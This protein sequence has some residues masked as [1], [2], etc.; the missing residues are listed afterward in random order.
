[1]QEIFFVMK[2]LFVLMFLP[3]F[4]VACTQVDKEDDLVVEAIECFYDSLNKGEIK[5]FSNALLRYDVV[6]VSSVEVNGNV[7]MAEV[8]CDDEFGNR[9]V[10][11]WNCLKTDGVWGV[12]VF[13]ESFSDLLK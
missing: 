13:D 6:E 10:C 3:L 8:V 2:R 5:G 4:V 7:A 9:I 12:N 1:M 11:N